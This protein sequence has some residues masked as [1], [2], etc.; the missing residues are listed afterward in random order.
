MDSIDSKFCPW[1]EPAVEPAKFVIGALKLVAGAVT[2]AGRP[3]ETGL[4]VGGIASLVPAESAFK[5]ALC[6]E[7]F[8]LWVFNCAI[9][10][11]GIPNEVLPFS[12]PDDKPLVPGMRLLDAPPAVAKP[13]GTAPA[14]VPMSEPES[15]FNPAAGSADPALKP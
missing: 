10:L 1:G 13:F 2:L 3:P 6:W 12:E 5:P 15:E 14:L 7:L 9:E 4:L 8:R 11:F